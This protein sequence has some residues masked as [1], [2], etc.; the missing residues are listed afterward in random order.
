MPTRRDG[1]RIRRV[2]IGLAAEPTDARAHRRRT[3]IGAIRRRGGAALALLSRPQPARRAGVAA[4]P[5]PN[6]RRA[7]Q[8]VPRRQAH[9]LHR[10]HLAASPDV[11]RGP[12]A[13]RPDFVLHDRLPVAPVDASSHS[14]GMV[15]RLVSERASRSSIS[16]CRSR[17]ASRR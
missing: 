3:C 15:R 14:A 9:P 8:P 6:P 13:A 17:R 7:G 10:G 4:D 12:A 2:V 1:C 5:C 11:A 16:R